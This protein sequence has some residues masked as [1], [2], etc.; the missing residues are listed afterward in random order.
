MSSCEQ[1]MFEVWCQACSAWSIHRNDESPAWVAAQSEW[2]LPEFREWEPLFNSGKWVWPRNVDFSVLWCFLPPEGPNRTSPLHNSSTNAV[3]PEG[4]N[5]FLKPGR[6]AFLGR[7]LILHL[8]RRQLTPTQVVNVISSSL[9]WKALL[10]KPLQ[11]STNPKLCWGVV[12]KGL[13]G[14]FTL[15]LSGLV[16]HRSAC[17]SL[18]CTFLTKQNES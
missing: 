6:P 2:G 16:A 9:L 11:V 18:I 13:A 12:W 8:D 7:W 3:L 17:G 5:P 4:L 1:K 10:S 15:V 14:M